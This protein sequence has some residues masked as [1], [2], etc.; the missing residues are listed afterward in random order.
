[1]KDK[2]IEDLFIAFNNKKVLIVGDCMIDEYIWGEINRMSPEAPVPIL[3]VKKKENRLGGAGNVARN[4]K[5]LGSIPILCSVI[6]DDEKGNE[7]ISLMKKNNLSTEG[8]FLSNER[9][10]TIKTRIIANNKHQIRIDQEEINNLSIEE[11]FLKKID[12][13]IQDIDV[14]ILQDYNKGIL[15]PKIIQSLINTG[16]KL[17]IPIIVDPKIKNFSLYKNCTIFKPNLKEIE[18]GM[19]IKLDVNNQNSL[20]V[21]TELLRKKLN[22]KYVLLT[23]SDKGIC[24][25][26]KEDFYYTPAAF[27]YDFLDVSG[28]GDTVL[29]VASLIFD[30]NINLKVLSQISSL[31]GGI[32]C[33][34]SGVVTI[35][36]DKLLNEIKKNLNQ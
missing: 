8:L 14:I 34:E 26:S 11:K 3:D 10:T 31:A 35:K 12:S 25:K 21:N 29:S 16:N 32:V 7:L 17:Q 13:L 5:S 36:K 4:I 15:T 27:K 33:Q 24:I 2:E 28:A 30:S 9:T 18:L 1:M 19:N 22:A 20:K 6:G 23:L